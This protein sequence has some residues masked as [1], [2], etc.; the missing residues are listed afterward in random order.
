MRFPVREVKVAATDRLLRWWRLYLQLLSSDSKQP[1]HPFS[2][3]VH[4][5]C[6]FSDD[7]IFQV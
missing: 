5:Q 3:I 4:N 2:S 6:C 1:F 7:G